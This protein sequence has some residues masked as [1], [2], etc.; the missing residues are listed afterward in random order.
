M[1]F[2]TLFCLLLVT[3]AYSQKVD[4]SFLHYREMPPAPTSFLPGNVL[5][6]MIDGL[7]YR[8]YWATEGLRPEDLRYRP[9]EEARSSS[10]TMDHILSL[11]TMIVNAAEGTPNTEATDP[12]SKLARS[13]REKVLNN[14]LKA[15]QLLAE[16]N[17]AEL[18]A[19][20]ITFNREGN[21]SEVAYW[22]MINGPIADAIYHTGQIVSFRR[23]SGNP[24]NPK[25]DVFRGKNRP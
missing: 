24:M 12:L 20:R 9:T 19:L 2:L 17:E 1:K 11:S 18:A 13:K 7:G 21:M 23:I 14:L 22:N 25:V 6:R 15:S 16:K 4:K 8:F 3:S 10:E 5:V